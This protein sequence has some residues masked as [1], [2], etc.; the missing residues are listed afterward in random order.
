MIR[1]FTLISAVAVI[2]ILFAGLGIYALSKM[3]TGQTKK[4]AAEMVA[5]NYA[6]TVATQIALL[7]ATLDKMAQD[8]EILAAISSHNRILLDAAATKLEAHLPN[9]LKIR[10]LLPN[11]SEPDQRAVPRMGFA[12]LDMVRETLSK[13]QAPAIQGDKGA[14]RHLAVARQVVD[15]GQTVAVILASMDPEFITKSLQKAT[16]NNGF[17]ELKQGKLTLIANG[18]KPEQDD[19]TVVLKIANSG[20]DIYYQADTSG[21]FS[22]LLLV[23]SLLLLCVLT[24]LL[25]IFV[26]YRKLSDVLS[27]DLRSVMKAF[28]DMMSSKM[29]G[30]YPVEL[31]EM[32]TV[33]STLAQFKRVL[34]NEESH[35]RPLSSEDDDLDNLVVID[36]ENYELDDFYYQPTHLKQ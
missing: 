22:D 16:L 13:N 10:L 23:C 34:D 32:G 1:F 15:N 20:W 33:I 5:K 12:D 7:E 2:L 36:D 21:D 19:D 18:N 30:N 28:K 26:T 3:E 24:A 35:H 6:L 14:D 29:Q 9:V 25:T 11:L 8:P 31:T 4:A 27:E 17:I